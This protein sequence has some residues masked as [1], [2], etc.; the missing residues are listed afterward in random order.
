M[1]EVVGEEGT[2]QVDDEVVVLERDAVSSIFVEV[3]WEGEL[4][5]K[6]PVEDHTVVFRM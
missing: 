4:I 1:A 3:A 6:E 5:R 2:V